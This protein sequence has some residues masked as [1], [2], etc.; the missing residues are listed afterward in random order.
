MTPKRA[1]NKWITTGL[2][3][4]NLRTLCQV[5]IPFRAIQCREVY[6][7]APTSV[8]GRWMKFCWRQF[9]TVGTEN[10]FGTVHIYTSQQQHKSSVKLQLFVQFFHFVIC[11]LYLK[12]SWV[13]QLMAIQQQ[14]MCGLPTTRTV[15]L[16]QVTHEWR[17]LEVGKHEKSC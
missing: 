10:H 7:H 4:K 6:V 2:K 13:V 12:G 11:R 1:R 17:I 3:G 14:I 9:N 5:A 8:S 15:P 16:F